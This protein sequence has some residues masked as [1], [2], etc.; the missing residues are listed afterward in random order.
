[1]SSPV[2][3]GDEEGEVKGIR[4]GAKK[5]QIHEPKGVSGLDPQHW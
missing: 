3:T 1:V 2:A 4:K 5:T